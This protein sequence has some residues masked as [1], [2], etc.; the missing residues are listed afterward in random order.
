MDRRALVNVV[1]L[2]FPIRGSH[3]PR[4]HGYALYSALS[5]SVPALHEAPWLG[6]HPVS[7]K[8]VG[9]DIFLGRGATLALRLPAD[10]IRTALSLAGIRLELGP[11]PLVL[12]A[13]SVYPLQPRA[14]LDARAVLLKLTSPPTRSSPGHDR[15]VLD[16]DALAD[17]Y[18][19][20]LRRQLRALGIDAEPQL[21]GR[22]TVTI[23]GK[24]L[25]GFSVRVAGL[26]ADASLLLQA[27]GLG[28]RRAMG[29]GIFRATRGA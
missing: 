21:T 17:R 10:E 19:A 1:D 12:G 26:D 20:E 29:C 3:V 13:P 15:G 24:R 6:V 5:R 23:R 25:V 16:N 27:R 14:S 11:G 28:G 2:S 9:D 7:G 4:D 22:R 18:R 8:L